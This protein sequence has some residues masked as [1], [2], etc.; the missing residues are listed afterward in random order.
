M[1]QNFKELIL[2]HLNSLKLD[3]TNNKTRIKTWSEIKEKLVK[4]QMAI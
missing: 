4:T 2:C 1:I 3:Q